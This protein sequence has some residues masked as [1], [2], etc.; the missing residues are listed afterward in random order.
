MSALVLTAPTFE[1][2]R[3]STLV[4]FTAATSVFTVSTLAF[5][6]GA[7]PFALHFVAAGVALV[8]QMIVA[9]DAI[10]S[11][12]AR[13][14]R[15]NRALG[16]LA[17]IGCGVPFVV[18]SS[19]HLRHHRHV[20]TASDP[21]RFILGPAW[22]LPL[23]GPAMLLFY[24]VESWSVLNARAR[25]QVVG[26]ALA[27]VAAVAVFPQLLVV[28]VAPLAFAA[29]LFATF[30][31]W[32]PHGPLAG[33]VMR[34]APALT[35]YHDDHHARPAVPALQYGELHDFHV[36]TGV[37]TRK[38][39]SVD[40]E[41]AG[42]ALG[43]RLLAEQSTRAVQLD[44][45]LEAVAVE[46]LGLDDAEAAFN[47]RLLEL[48]RRGP[49]LVAPSV[50]ELLA[51]ALRDDAI[52][53]LLAQT[54]RQLSTHPRVRRELERGDDAL[55]AA[56]VT[57]SRRLLRQPEGEL[58]FDPRRSPAAS[59]RDV[60]VATAVLRGL[61]SKVK[62]DVWAGSPVIVRPGLKCRVFARA[63]G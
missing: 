29:F 63:Q 48:T 53:L 14:F 1:V 11:A 58:T 13:D 56:A 36:L 44:P 57:E 39:S 24:Y 27:V 55:L 34:V 35:G 9:H 25:A 41:A 31:V 6:S 33:W 21:E 15:L 3:G 12:A 4:L 61:F 46:L 52:D 20:G 16:W 51:P 30:T 8:L 38:S 17:S 19:N 50:A 45:H 28:W 54:I 49:R 22:Q 32:L 59:S 47:R 43:E 5:L 60:R 10:H 7:L 40:A 42:R 2:R 26:F 23:R 37:E 62:L 18:L